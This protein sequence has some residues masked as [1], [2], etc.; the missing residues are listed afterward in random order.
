MCWC[1]PLE[2]HDEH[3]AADHPG[4]SCVS[5][6]LL[7]RRVRCLSWP[8]YI[9][10]FKLLNTTP[11]PA[12]TIDRVFSAYTPTPRLHHAQQPGTPPPPHRPPLRPDWRAPLV[13]TDPLSL[14]CLLV[15]ALFVCL[16]LCCV[17]HRYGIAY[18][19]A[20][21]STPFLGLGGGYAM[22]GWSTLTTN[23]GATGRWSDWFFQ[24][25][26][27]ATATTIPAGCVAERFN[28]NAYLG[29]WLN[30]CCCCAVAPRCAVSFLCCAGA[31]CTCA[32]VQH[33]RTGALSGMQYALG[34]CT[35]LPSCSA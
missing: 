26:F 33:S 14:H 3:P 35:R 2:E 30:G 17:L 9:T 7:S 31:E 34:C 19:D 8:G 5:H 15:A 1:H 12:C 11:R 23:S 29:E 25:A 24:W 10:A 28:F 20:N 16:C 6:L 13:Q 22:K 21:N 32:S 4:R 18:G 27:A